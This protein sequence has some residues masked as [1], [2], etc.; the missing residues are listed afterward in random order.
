M[1]V[2]VFYSNY[3]SSAFDAAT[4]VTIISLNQY[5]GHKMVKCQPSYLSTLQDYTWQAA[6]FFLISE[7]ISGIIAETHDKTNYDILKFS[8][9]NAIS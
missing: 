7:C 9:L 2:C 3:Q 8:L 6:V 1:K 4:A 5:C